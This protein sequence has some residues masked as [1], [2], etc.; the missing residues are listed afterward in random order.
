MAT[1]IWIGDAQDIAQVDTFTVGGTI[2]VGDEFSVKIGNRTITAVATTTV[3]DTTVADIITALE[4]ASIYPEFYGLIITN[5]TA[6]T[7]GTFTITYPAGASYTATASTTESGGGAAD[8]QTFTKVTTTTATGSAWWDNADNWDTGTV[9]VNT[10]DVI[11]A[12]SARSI[13]EGLD[14][15]AVTLTSLKILQSFTGHIGLPEFAATSVGSYEEYRDKYLQIHASDLEIGEGPGTGSGR[16]RID[17]LTTEIDVIVHNTGDRA[18]TN[19]PSVLWKGTHIANTMTIN[20]GFVG[21]AFYPGEAAA[22]ASLKQTY[23]TK[24]KTDTDVVVGNG[25]TQL[26]TVAKNG[27]T[28]Q[29]STSTTVMVLAGLGT[30]TVLG[31]THTAVIIYSG[32]MYY[33]SSGTITSLTVAGPNSVAD[34]G[35]DLRLRTITDTYMFAGG[36]LLDPE[37]TITY[38]NDAY[39]RCTMA[40]VTLNLGT[41]F[42]LGIA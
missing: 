19:V 30:T 10:D 31:G 8:L 38:T 3:V 28:L 25:V 35:R 34:F 40:E 17:N 39:I 42:R 26:T 5:T 36:T 14:Q 1:K 12:N 33:Q 23:R 4:G 9:P 18:E 16:I 11:I 27:G 21:I 6:T 32:T 13:T 41:D 22:L 29:L 7:T 15:S 37:K 2:E 20:K 24:P